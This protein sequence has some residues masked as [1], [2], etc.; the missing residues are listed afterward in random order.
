MPPPAPCS[1]ELHE[2]LAEILALEQ[3]DETR[4]GVVDSLDDRLAVLELALGEAARKARERFAVAISPVEHDHSLH[5]DAVDQHRAHVAVSIRL[6][7]AVIPDQAADD[8]AREQVHEGQR[9]IED[10]ATDVLE[11]DVHAPRT[12]L[13]QALLQIARL[14]VDAGVVSQL[15]HR[16]IALDLAARDADHAP[17]FDLRELPG[18][19][20]PR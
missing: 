11:A 7:E 20:A 1:R 13:A 3:R 9:R 5:P 2:L 19:A 16:V 18:D 14:V 17:A 10:L 8:D 12:R 6:G 4:G 15:L